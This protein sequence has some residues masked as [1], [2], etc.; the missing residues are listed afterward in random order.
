MYT[1]VKM[2]ERIVTGLPINFPTRPY[3]SSYQSA[4]SYCMSVVLNYAHCLLGQSKW[5]VLEQAVYNGLLYMHGA[6]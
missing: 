6:Q 3:Q 4:T 2:Y 1:C 5:N